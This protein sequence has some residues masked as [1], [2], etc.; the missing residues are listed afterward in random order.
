MTDPVGGTPVEPHAACSSAS[1][2]DLIQDQFGRQ[3]ELFARAP[4]LHADAVLDLMVEA[5]QPRPGDVALDVACGPGTVVASLAPHVR[6]AIGLDATAEMLRQARDLAAERA[7]TNVGWHLGDVYRLP[8][9][10]AAFDVVSCRFAFHHFE[11]PAR[12]LAEMIRVCRDGGR[13]VLCDGVAADDPA[14]AEAFNRMERY[15]DPSTVA[16]RPLAFLLGL[17]ADAGLAVA[18][19]RVF[20]VP[21]ELER[22][23]ALSFPVDDDRDGLRRMIEAS[24]DG[25][26]MGMDARREA[27]TVKLAYPS[28]VLAARKPAAC[29]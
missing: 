25:D 27:G 21:A 13:I 2:R 1:H 11:H 29:D 7:L 10:N 19:T 16:F 9:A 28:V 8:F 14:K 12:A 17:F 23:I 24:V 20:Q 26:G 5:A 3:A 6:S 22:L 18:A 4:A 15:R